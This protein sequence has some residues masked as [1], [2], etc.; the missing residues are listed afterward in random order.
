MRALQA[1][2]NSR[3]CPR[4]VH[5][6]IKCNN[7]VTE[8]LENPDVHPEYLGKVSK[9]MVTH[10]RWHFGAAVLCVFRR[11]IRAN[12]CMGFAEGSRDEDVIARALRE[13]DPSNRDETSAANLSKK[14]GICNF[15]PFRFLPSFVINLSVV[16]RLT[17]TLLIRFTTLKA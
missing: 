9:T 4:T 14:R 10:R 3:G 7:I 2:K 12:G 1:L 5:R 11:K 13:L 8:P 15:L 17:N 6:L 16:T